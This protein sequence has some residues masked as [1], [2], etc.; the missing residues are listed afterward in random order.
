SHITSI[1]EVKARDGWGAIDAVQN[2]RIYTVKVDWISPNP[3]TV[4]GIEYFAYWFHPSLFSEPTSLVSGL[5]SILHGISV[6]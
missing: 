4:L 1:E 6:N 2:D 3:R 5:T